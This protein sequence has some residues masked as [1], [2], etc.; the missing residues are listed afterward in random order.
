MSV[1][2]IVLAGGRSSRFGSD[3]L[4]A[5]LEGRRLL[6]HA[7]EAVATVAEE[8]VVVISP[9]APEPPLVI[10]ARFARDPEP[11]GGPLV[12]LVAGLDVTVHDRIIVVAGDMPT[13]EP[14]VL[15][16]VL[17]RLDMADAA[18]LDT[19]DGLSPFPLA[20][21]RSPGVIT[22]RQLV[23]AGERRFLALT[24][25]LSAIHVPASAW[26]ALDPLRRTLRDVDR[27]EDLALA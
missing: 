11:F 23:A 2:A 22:A 7:V 12:G 15:R 25:A 17:D 26:T 14:A 13:L 21:R 1:G 16:L 20:L 3:K 19:E 6:A 9:H 27:P 18:A 24:E 5:P 8:I 4:A 10:P